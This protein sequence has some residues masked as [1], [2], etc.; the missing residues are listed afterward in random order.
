MSVQQNDCGNRILFPV[1][2]SDERLKTN[3]RP[4]QIVALAAV[5]VVE[6]D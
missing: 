6:C 3:I 2:Y 1:A 5:E 4:T